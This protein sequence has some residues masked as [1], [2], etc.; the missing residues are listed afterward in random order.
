MGLLPIQ[1]PPDPLAVTY[2]LSSIC[3]L[4]WLPPQ[5]AFWPE[6]SSAER[7]PGVLVGT[8]LTIARRGM[9]GQRHPALHEEEGCQK[10]KGGDPSPLLCL[11]EMQLKC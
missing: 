8:K 5:A 11:G 9:E 4:T 10:V 2:M 1:Q 6:R 7:D 3:Q